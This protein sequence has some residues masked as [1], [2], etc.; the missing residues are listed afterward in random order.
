[1]PAPDGLEARLPEA[2]R[3]F[4]I[5]NACR[6][7]EGY[8]AVFPA[9]E[10]RASFHAGDLSQLANLCHDCRACFQACMYADPHEFAINI[11]ALLAEARLDSYEHYTRPRRL[12]RMFEAGPAALGVSTV[13]VLA[14]FL[15]IYAAF[16]PLED[17]FEVRT[18][19]GSFYEVVSHAAMAVPAVLLAG[20]GIAVA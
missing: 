6:Y 9:M 16:A 15:C 2:S 19:E 7:C 11:P 5:C 1:M 12:R 8:C 17:L 3:Q 18:G 13:A 10:L 4:T 14:I 20:F